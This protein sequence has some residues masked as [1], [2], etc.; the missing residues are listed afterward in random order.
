MEKQEYLKKVGVVYDT[1]VFA[2][3]EFNA[4][5]ISKKDFQNIVRVCWMAAP[6]EYQLVDEE[7][8][9]SLELDEKLVGKVIRTDDYFPE[10]F[11][12]L[13]A[14]RQ[15][16]DEVIDNIPNLDDSKFSVRGSNSLIPYIIGQP[17]W[18]WFASGHR[19]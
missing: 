3:N 7:M 6:K 15:Y 19:C 9:E 5:K 17:E 2:I 18:N 14:W 11:G 12:D 10:C 13:D 1:L 4:N 16:V 8:A